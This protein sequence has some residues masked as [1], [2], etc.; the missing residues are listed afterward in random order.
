VTAKDLLAD[1]TRRGVRFA[2]IGDRLRL[3]PAEAIP[4]E[5]LEQLRERKPEILALLR[6]QA[7]DQPAA[8]EPAGG[9]ELSSAH[10]LARA[11]A[12]ARGRLERL[13]LSLAERRGYPRVQLARGVWLLPGHDSW[14]R[15]V[16]NACTRAEGLIRAL[17]ELL[18]R[19]VEG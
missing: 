5:L 1:L 6:G 4:P 8:T 10:Q 17:E 14:R 9:Q 11:W 2:V 13:V 7:A 12:D 3:S 19:P 16:S 18:G 15:F